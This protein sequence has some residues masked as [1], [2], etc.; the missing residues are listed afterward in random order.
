MRIL[1]F[2]TIF[3][4]LMHNTIVCCNRFVSIDDLVTS[5]QCLVAQ[6]REGRVM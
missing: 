2:A 3:K 4:L 5:M 1:G 6:D